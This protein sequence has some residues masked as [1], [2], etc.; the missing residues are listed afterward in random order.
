[1]NVRQGQCVGLLSSASTPL[2]WLRSEVA[3]CDSGSSPLGVEKPAQ[4][5]A[6]HLYRKKLL[7]LL[8]C[9]LRGTPAGFPFTLRLGLLGADSVQSGGGVATPERTALP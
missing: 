6:M 3:L 9:C 7:A 1:M 4:L 2:S 5:F 8:R